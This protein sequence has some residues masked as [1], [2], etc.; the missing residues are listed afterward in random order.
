MTYVQEGRFTHL[1]P[2]DD[3]IL[4]SINVSKRVPLL[5]FFLDDVEIGSIKDAEGE[6]VPFTYRSNYTSKAFGP[7]K[8]HMG[9]PYFAMKKGRTYLKIFAEGGSSEI[10][11]EWNKIHP[12]TNVEDFPPITVSFFGDEESFRF[13]V[14]HGVAHLNKTTIKD[15]EFLDI[16][17]A[18]DQFVGFGFPEGVPD[19]MEI[20]VGGRKVGTLKNLERYNSTQFNWKQA[21]TSCNGAFPFFVVN[22][23]LQI[24]PIGSDCTVSLKYTTMDDVTRKYLQGKTTTIDF[25]G[26]TAFCVFDNGEPVFSEAHL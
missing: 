15:G 17:R 26:E 3:D 2:F 5:R 19:K 21:N 23:N 20:Y 10:K 25:G 7:A 11:V 18:A 16:P 24:R 6:I 22:S 13:L 14:S 8:I 4:M 1:I 9:L 12:D